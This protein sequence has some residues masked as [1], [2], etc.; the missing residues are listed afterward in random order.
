MDVV[1]IAAAS[2]L[3]LAVMDV[4]EIAAASNLPNDPVPDELMVPL[5]VISFI[6]ELLT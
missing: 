5:A 4:A 1:E 3:P 2:N 6:V